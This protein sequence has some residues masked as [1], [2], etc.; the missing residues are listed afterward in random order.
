M[1][2]VG[3]VV[4]KVLASIFSLGMIFSPSLDLFRVLKNKN[5]G[6]MA[7]MP[8]VGL[9]ISCHLWYVLLSLYCYM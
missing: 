1:V 7:L 2:N 6:E 9:W 3:L 4:L 5:T 8:L